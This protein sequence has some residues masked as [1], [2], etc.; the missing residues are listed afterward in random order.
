MRPLY[1]YKTSCLFYTLGLV[2]LHKNESY[3]HTHIHM[4]NM[5][6]KFLPLLTL[7][8]WPQCTTQTFNSSHTTCLGTP[9][10]HDCI[11]GS[12]KFKT[13]VLWN[14]NLNFSI[15]EGLISWLHKLISV[16]RK[17]ANSRNTFS[18][19]SRIKK[20]NNCKPQISRNKYL[21]L[22]TAG[23]SKEIGSPGRLK[24]FPLG[25]A[26]GDV[27]PEVEEVSTDSGTCLLPYS[28]SENK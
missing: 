8:C 24:T 27:A 10:G 21:A 25:L 18:L 28:S 14:S 6:D 15:I 7:Q 23:L 4:S 20:T 3:I 12:Y 11:E 17:L 1:G 9:Y 5:C 19:Y 26:R 13:P 16:Y 2:P 22:L